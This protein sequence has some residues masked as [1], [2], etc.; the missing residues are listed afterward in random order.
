MGLSPDASDGGTTPPFINGVLSDG[1]V[2]LLIPQ[3]MCS[4][5]LKLKILNGHSTV[6]LP[7]IRGNNKIFCHGVSMVKGGEGGGGGGHRPS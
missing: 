3:F 1:M 4:G 5:R 2:D 7:R 6:V